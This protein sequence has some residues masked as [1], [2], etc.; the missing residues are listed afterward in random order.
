MDANAAIYADKKSLETRFSHRTRVLDHFW[1]NLPTICSQGDYMSEIIRQSDLGIVVENRNPHEFADAILKL[2]TDKKL[3]ADI[4]QN[5]MR[6][7]EDFTWE[8]TLEPLVSYLDKVN[9]PAVQ[10]Q[11]I[12]SYRKTGQNRKL[13]MK[14]RI[15]HSAR[16]LLLGR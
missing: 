11:I 1:A 10:Q 4:Q 5:L 7:R 3:F 12:D 14:R 15:R 16:I 6:H 9:A 2:K 13:S 8:K